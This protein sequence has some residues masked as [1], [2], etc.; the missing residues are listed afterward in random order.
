MNSLNNQKQELAKY[1]KEDLIIAIL[2][3][4]FRGYISNELPLIKYARMCIEAQ[5]MS[6]KAQAY[7]NSNQLLL[8]SECF[9]KSNKLYEKANDFLNRSRN[10]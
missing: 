5:N 8:A 4:D 10:D 3:H 7:M 2:K 6:D 9:D 1:T